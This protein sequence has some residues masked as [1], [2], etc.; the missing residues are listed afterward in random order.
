MKLQTFTTASS[1]WT[2]DME[3]M[4]FVRTPIVEGAIHPRVAYSSETIPFLDAYPLPDGRV[5]VRTGVTPYD[6]VVSGT[7]VSGEFQA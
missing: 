4:T 2:F 3:D 7:L 1:T 6:Y 5:F